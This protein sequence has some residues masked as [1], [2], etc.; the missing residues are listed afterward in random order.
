MDIKSIPEEYQEKKLG[1]FKLPM[2]NFSRLAGLK[3]RPNLWLILS[4]SLLVL[5][6][7]IT[8]GL[9]GYK[10]NLIQQK[11][12]LETQIK[13]L[14][15]QRDLGLETKLI[16]LEKN[17]TALKKFLAIHIYPSKLFQILEEITLPQV[18]LTNFSTDLS[19]GK[20]SLAAEAAN[21]STLAKQLM[22]F[23]QDTRIKKVEVSGI[24]LGSGGQVDFN[25][26]IEFDSQFL[27]PKSN[28]L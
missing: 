1:G 27:K 11:A 12:A 21:Y 18:Q 17:I 26:E 6:I 3:P 16:E 4:V 7:L 19:T 24:N 9:F 25:L 15:E 10:N 14:E 28:Q 8:L 22:A 20:I 13:E 23:E 2:I 5:T